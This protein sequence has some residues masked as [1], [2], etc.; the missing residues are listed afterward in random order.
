VLRCNNCYMGPPVWGVKKFL[1]R[2]TKST[3]CSFLDSLESLC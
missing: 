2:R 1:L 3:D